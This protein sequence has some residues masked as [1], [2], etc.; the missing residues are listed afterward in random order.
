M[1][2]GSIFENAIGDL[3]GGF[4]RWRVWVALASEDISDQH[5]RTTLG[6][7]WLLLN[8]LAFAGTFILIFGRG[9]GIP[10]YQSYVAIGLFVW[11]Y[12]SELITQSVTL[13]SR[14]ESFI[15]GTSLPVSVYVLRLTM[16]SVIRAGYMLA[17]CL[18]FLLIAGTPISFGW[19]WAAAGLAL[20]FMIAPAAI[21]VFAMAGTFFP[22]LQFIVSN[23]MRLGLFLTPIF[24]T[25]GEGDGFRQ[26]LSDWNPFTYFLDIVRTPV[27]T[28]ELPAFSLSLC[29]VTGVLIWLAALILLGRFRRQIVFVL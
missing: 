14:E 19:L 6:P 13:F 11:L 21:T 24:W 22:D 27:L 12:M 25:V 28:G 15:K 5:R 9:E 20:I 3:K 16:Q 4:S 2:V 29:A 18:V 10:D 26:L 23:I 17:G 1:T 8:Y 7:L